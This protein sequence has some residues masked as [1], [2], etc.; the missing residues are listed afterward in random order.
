MSAELETRLKAALN[1]RADLVHPEDLPAL[2]V[3]TAT[4]TPL[5][6][7]P[8]PWVVGA[9]AAAVVVA[10]PLALRDGTDELSP[11]PSPSGPTRLFTPTETSTGAPDDGRT[12][13]GDLDG[14][15]DPEQITINDQGVVR[16]TY[17]QL[18]GDWAEIPA[19]GSPGTTLAGLA[20]IDPAQPKA[21][22]IVTDDHGVGSVFRLVPNGGFILP[23]EVVVNGAGDYETFNRDEDGQQWGITASGQLVTTFETS[24]PG[25]WYTHH[26]ALAPNG[27]LDS[28]MLGEMCSEGGNMPAPC[29]G[30]EGVTGRD[31]LQVALYPETTEVLP[32]GETMTLGIDGGGEP[33]QVS[34]EGDVLT[35]DFG[36]GDPDSVTIPGEGRKQ[37]LTTV[38]PGIEVP[39]LI[40]R[41]R[42]DNGLLYYDVVS[43]WNG[44][45]TVIDGGDQLYAG[46]DQ[47][48]W[49]SATGRIFTRWPSQQ[50][51]GEFLKSWSVSGQT[52]ESEEITNVDGSKQICFDFADGQYGTC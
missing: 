7:R 32:A 1:A 2:E 47:F 14:D 29:G 46:D 16:I 18:Q 13:T 39:G 48:T 21:M 51:N 30:G 9:A 34:L 50:G 49:V 36:T 22:A 27:K 26:W 3:P 11:A 41:H 4:V 12:L 40:V 24:A 6:R 43:W 20:Q 17:S 10:V 45:L 37:L 19:A 28:A 52:L 44:E 25:I 5:V 15:G 35:V 42:E 31:G 33:G 8:V 23:E 38:L